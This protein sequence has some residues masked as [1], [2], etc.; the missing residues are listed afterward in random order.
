M[1]NLQINYDNL[2]S[3]DKDSLISRLVSCLEII[4]EPKD[5][6]GKWKHNRESCKN[7]ADRA[8]DLVESHTGKMCPDLE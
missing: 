4:S 2:S 3:E 1:K 7:L 8:L 6:K 5:S